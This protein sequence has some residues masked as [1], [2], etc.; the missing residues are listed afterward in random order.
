MNRIVKVLVVDDH[1][2]VARATKELLEQI[3]RI[4][5]VGIAGNAHVC[6]E[7][8]SRFEPD[9]VFLDYQLPDQYGSKVAEQIKHEYPMTHIVIFSGNDL[10]DV[11]NQLLEI[12]VSGIIS[13]EANEVTIKNMVN[14]ILDNHTVIPIKLFHQMRMTDFDVPS[15]AEVT[16][17]DDDVQ[18][19][20]MMVRG[21]SV[22][23]IAEKLDVSTFSVGNYFNQ[24]FGK[25]GVKSR[26]QAVEK[27]VKSK[28]FAQAEMR[29]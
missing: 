26:E 10:T 4:E 8:M 13:K 22:E 5:V 1:P 18:I 14:C 24:I 28:Y 6:M 7:Y 2:V 23:Q 27:F 9:I 16:L 21:A 12:G 20:M 11:F 17:T 19:L 3:D 25:L 29:N 15:L